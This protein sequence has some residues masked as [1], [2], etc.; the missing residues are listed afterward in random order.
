[1]TSTWVAAVLAIGSM[2]AACSSSGGDSSSSPAASVGASLTVKDFEFS[3]GSLSVASGSSTITVMNTGT[4]KHSFTLDDDSVSQD[5]E[6]GESQTVTVNLTAD[7]PF[8]CKFHT[9]MT[10]T[11]TIG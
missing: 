11:L 10:G 7:A 6:P 3:P 2:A 8:H 4:H 9:Q 5:I 1:M